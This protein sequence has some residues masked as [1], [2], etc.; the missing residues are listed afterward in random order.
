MAKLW[1]KGRGKLGPLQP[2]IGTWTADAP[3][4]MGPV[5]CR[6]SFVTDLGGQYVRLAARWEIG[7]G[8]TPRIYE[9]SALIGVDAEGTVR[10]WS[11][12]SDGKQSQGWLADVTDLHPE[13]VG[14]EADMP[15][16]RARMA[17]WPAEDGG[18]HWVV[19]AR[20]AKGW[21]RFTDHHYHREE[22]A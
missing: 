7:A 14:F 2:L 19:E 21:R 6:R 15:A 12:T 16:G 10:F 4:E 1:K 18:V 17:Y 5:H 22:Q 8:A 11:F 20:G 13:A 3:S 9:E